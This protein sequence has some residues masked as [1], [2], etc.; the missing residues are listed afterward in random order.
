MQL[1]FLSF[2]NFAVNTRQHTP[3]KIDYGPA[4]HSRQIGRH[5]RNDCERPQPS[6]RKLTCDAS[7]LKGVVI[8][9]RN[10]ADAMENVNSLSQRRRPHYC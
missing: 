7:V 1:S 3:G 4:I 5:R 9:V 2:P 8:Y 6:S 10:V